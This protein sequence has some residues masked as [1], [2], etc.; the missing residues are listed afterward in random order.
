M[1]ALVSG[2]SR[3]IGAAVCLRI[4]EAA[5]REASARRLQ[6]VVVSHPNHKKMLPDQCVRWGAMPLL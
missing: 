5:V 6:S 4:T 2:G 3:G 1:R